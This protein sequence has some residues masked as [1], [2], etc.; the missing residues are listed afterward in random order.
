MNAWKLSPLAVVLMSTSALV[1]NAVAI[2]ATGIAMGSGITITPAVDL[3]VD[4]N[5]NVYSQA[6]DEESSVITRLTPSIGLVG[7]YGQTQ[8][9]AYYEAEQGL[10]TIDDNDNYLDQYIGG[11]ASFEL[12]DSHQLDFNA[13]YND[14]HDARGSGTLE[15]SN[16]L[17]LAHPDKYSEAKAGMKYIFGTESSIAN[18]DVFASGYQ[19]RYSNNEIVTSSREHNKIRYGTVLAM[20]VSPRTGIL[21]E[22]NQEDITYEEGSITT[23]KREGS[24][25]QV[26]A[27]MRWDITGITSGSV[28]I[29][30]SARSF[31]VSGLDTEAHFS[32][33]AD[34][35][36]QPLTYSTVVLKGAQENKETNGLGSYINATN[37]TLTWDHQFTDLLSAGVI[38][39][40]GEDDYIG[41]NS[42]GGKRREDT[43]KVFGIKATYSPMIWMDV[44]GSVRNTSS[45]SNNNDFDND[46]TLVS[47]GVTLAI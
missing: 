7:D 3:K 18:V 31:D 21:L 45:L 6:T 15:G 24:N 43:N 41:D 11:D 13:S 2:E 36:W 17:L 32:W 28:Q 40:Y 14:A 23:D 30:R 38:A 16:A 44:D 34:L 19:K 4:H 33:K 26:L 8:V 37:T 47:V 20:A 9:G 25:Q 22:L 29:G 35:T 46:V 5:D 39:A 27:G 12:T 1:N 42:V 10:Y